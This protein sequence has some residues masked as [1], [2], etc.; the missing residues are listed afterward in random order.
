LDV[1]GHSLRRS[2]QPRT[3]QQKQRNDDEGCS[4]HGLISY[5][6]QMQKEGSKLSLAPKTLP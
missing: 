5:Y 1:G 2:R 6:P 4:F 3:E